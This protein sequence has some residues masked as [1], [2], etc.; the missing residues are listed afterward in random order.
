MVLS[1]KTSIKTAPEE[2]GMVTHVYRIPALRRLSQEG[3]E[4]KA[5]LPLFREPLS[6]KQINN[7]QN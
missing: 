2:L 3:Q 7:S 5:S 6:Q 1:H 4:F